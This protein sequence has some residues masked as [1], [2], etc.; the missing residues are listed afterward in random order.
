[1][2]ASSVL[3]E[4]L[5]G[6]IC[7]TALATIIA[8]VSK[9]ADTDIG[10]STLMLTVLGSMLSFALSLRVSSSYERFND[11]RRELSSLSGNS[12]RRALTESDQ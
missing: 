7:F 11:G 4:V 5:P 6:T 2:L 9:L 3:P 10:L 12:L 8:C 1:M